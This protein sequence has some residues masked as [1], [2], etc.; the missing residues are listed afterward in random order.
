MAKTIT[1]QFVP[2]YAVHPGEILEEVLEA[3]GISQ[4]EFAERSGLTQK[5]ISWIITRKNRVSSENA[6]VFE[7]ILGIS[8]E[9]WNNLDAEFDLF[10]ARQKAMDSLDDAVVEWSQRFPLAE[11]IRRGALP[12]IRDVKKQAA[13]LLKFFRVKD[14]GAWTNIYDTVY[15]FRRSAAFRSNYEAVVSWLRLAEIQ[16][17]RIDTEVY[18]AAVFKKALS[19]IRLLTDKGPEIFEP[20]MKKLCAESGVSLAF[21]SELHGTHLSGAT[22]WLTSDKAMIALSLRHKS[23]DHFWFTFYHEA[24]HIVKHGKKDVYVDE[25]NERVDVTIREEQEANRFAAAFLIPES[26]YQ[27]F[28]SEHPN[29]TK[30]TVEEFANDI[31]IAP[32]IIVGRLQHDKVIE[33]SWLNDL[34]VKFQLIEN[35]E[36]T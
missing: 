6:I 33:F 8:A 36:E 10:Q 34:K 25:G 11:L 35:N 18:N 4:T 3:R 26:E 31:G 2:D 27:E 17:E 7:R 12:K 23:N 9:I 30:K 20:K 16:A 32:G 15:R 5:T 19:K 28:V 21:V 1:N 14:L 22:R 13:A 29:L 24:G